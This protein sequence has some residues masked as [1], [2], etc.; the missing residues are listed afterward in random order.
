MYD[1]IE[2]IKN[3]QKANTKI[4]MLKSSSKSE[5]EMNNE[6]K[7]FIINKFPGRLFKINL[8]YI[9]KKYNG[10]IN[11]QL[12]K[13]QKVLE[14]SEKMDVLSFID[15]Y[16]NGEIIKSIYDSESDDC[17]D[18]LILGIRFKDSEEKEL[19]SECEV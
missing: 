9:G 17:K 13:V 8:K 5:S 15:K 12:S 1:I 6:I 19:G 3:E 2:R 7:N 4:R 14:E 18:I 10:F 16:L 11:I